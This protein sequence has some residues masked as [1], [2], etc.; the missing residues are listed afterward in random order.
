MKKIKRILITGMTGSQARPRTSRAR[1]DYPLVA[2]IMHHWL[3]YLGYHVDHK[4][5]TNT[6]DLAAYDLVICG[7]GAFTSIV[8]TFCYQALWIA[9][10]HDNVKYFV[11]DWQSKLNYPTKASSIPLFREFFKNLQHIEGFQLT[12]T[13]RKQLDRK[14]HEITNGS[15]TP[16]VGMFPW[17]DHSIFTKGTYIKECLPVDFF[18]TLLTKNYSDDLDH[19][20]TKKKKT[21]VY[22]SLMNRSKD[23]DKIK[24]ASSWEIEVYNS[25]NYIDE[26]NLTQVY[27]NNWGGVIP[28]YYHDSCGYAR[29]R[30]KQLIAAKS[31]ALI[32]LEDAKY[33]G[34]SYERTIDQYENMSNRQLEEIAHQQAK[35][36]RKSLNPLEVELVNLQKYL[37]LK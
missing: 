14:F 15:I 33:L 5:V 20:P 16:I 35:Q 19:I 13:I 3:T 9:T 12:P 11:D 37:G 10:R 4:I 1:R 25:K 2:N 17:G 6:K 32:D 24:Q 30:Y 28:T 34:D 8:S 36:F 27:A 31:I 26:S 22:A 23:I 18:G 21:W 7:L 29:P